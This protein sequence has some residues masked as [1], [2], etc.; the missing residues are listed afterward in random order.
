[1]RIFVKEWVIKAVKKGLVTSIKVYATITQ[2]YVVG[3][4]QGMLRP[5]CVCSSVGDSV[6]GNSQGSRLVNTVGLPLG[7]V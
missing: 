2:V 5:G 7:M 6:S 4:Q 1:M 3:R